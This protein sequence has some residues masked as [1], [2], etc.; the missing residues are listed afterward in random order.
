M[1]RIELRAWCGSP[2]RFSERRRYDLTFGAE[3]FA[4]GGVE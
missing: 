1:A 4:R 3:I 2:A